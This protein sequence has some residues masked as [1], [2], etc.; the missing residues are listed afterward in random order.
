MN[1]MLTGTAVVLI[2][3]FVIF[4]WIPAAS[5]ANL[6]GETG[7]REAEGIDLAY[8]LKVAAGKARPDDNKC[9]AFITD[10]N[11]LRDSVTSCR[12]VGGTLTPHPRATIFSLDFDGDGQAEYLYEFNANFDCDGAASLFSCGDSECPKVLYRKEQGKW[13]GIGAFDSTRIFTLPSTGKTP[14]PDLKVLCDDTGQCDSVNYS[15]NGAKY[16]ENGLS[17]R[18]YSIL[19]LRPP[20]QGKLITLQRKLKVLAE[21]RAGSRSV[22]EYDRGAMFAIAGQAKGS[23]YLYVSPCNACEA[24]FVQKRVLLGH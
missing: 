16:E 2:A 11:A 21:P 23:N 18:G 15:W 9:P 7:V 6:S 19:R 17:L 3:G 14:H 5:A 24:G 4:C 13:R 20:L 22:G 10:Q 8:C 1:R 12:E